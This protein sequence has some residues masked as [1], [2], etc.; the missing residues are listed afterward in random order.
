MGAAAG[1]NSAVTAGVGA[2]STTDGGDGS[3]NSEGGKSSGAGG[4]G[5]K[6]G[7]GGGGAGCTRL[8][9]SHQGRTAD[10]VVFESDKT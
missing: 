7:A 3:W 4:G 5:L 2:A 1:P 9:L 6:M 10:G 8:L